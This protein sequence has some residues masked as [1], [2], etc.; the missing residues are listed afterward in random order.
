MYITSTAQS[1]F[2][3][4]TA[5]AACLLSFDDGELRLILPAELRRSTVPG[6]FEVL[7]N[8][9]AEHSGVQD[10]SQ[11]QISSSFTVKYEDE[12]DP[13]ALDPARLPIEEESSV[14]VGK[15][16]LPSLPSYV[17]ALLLRPTSETVDGQP[18]SE[19]LSE[20]QYWVKHIGVETDDIKSVVA[21]PERS[22]MS[23]AVTLRL[24]LLF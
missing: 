19:P 5:T 24:D 22:L 23:A 10:Q 13:D 4:S 8:S 9:R 16:P 20:F 6:C 1:A 18:M 21:L 7:L 14:C 3:M 12:T 17:R 15:L 11:G 2:N